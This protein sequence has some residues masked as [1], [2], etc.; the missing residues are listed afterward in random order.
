MMTNA[1]EPTLDTSSRPYRTADQG[2]QGAATY[3]PGSRFGGGADPWSRDAD[4]GAWSYGEAE[5]GARSAD[6]RSLYATDPEDRY[7]T[8]PRTGVGATGPQ[9]GVGADG[10]AEG[11]RAGAT[12]ATGRDGTPPSATGLRALPFGL[13]GRGSR[14]GRRQL[15][16][17]LGLLLGSTA[18]LVSAALSQG[19]DTVVPVLS[20]LAAVPV[21]PDQ[22]PIA[23]RP[24][25][26]TAPGTC[27]SW[28]R[29]DAADVVAVDCAGPHLFEQAGV[30]QLT[31]YPANAPLPDDASFRSL[32]NDQ[33]TKTVSSYLGGR[34]DPDGAFRAGALKPSQKAWN[35]GDRSMRCGLQRFSRSGALY[36]IT[37]KV[38][39]QD[40]ADVRPAGTCLGIDGKFIGDPVGCGQPHAIESVGSVDLGQKFS[41]YPKVGDQDSY[42]QP[43][44]AKIASAWVGGDQALASKNL[45]VMWDNLTEESW[46]AGTRKVGCELA[47]QLPDKSGFAPITGEAKGKVTVS[48]VP[49][50][51]AQPTA[52]PGAPAE[53]PDDLGRDAADGAGAGAGGG[54]APNGQPAPPPRDKP[55]DQKPLGN[56]Q[57]HL[58]SLPNPFKPGNGDDTKPGNGDDNKPPRPPPNPLGGSDG[59]PLLGG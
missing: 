32:V 58:P 22:R 31:Q 11:G 45:S 47:A 14:L 27:L 30:V 43:Q 2:D 57:P 33:C 40:Q 19:A 6:S 53:S 39:Q 20:N 36:P 50:P 52:Q 9:D 29:A 13:A 41:K 48:D 8:G 21:P 17:V 28:Q 24:P 3:P 25:P 46:S 12:S 49:A 26:P 55:E 7:A 54:P 44:C 35:D 4:Q 23:Q 38:A 10:T 59:K 16:L 1:M 51:A 42:L 18:M 15:G 37:G 5:P 34:Y 56:D